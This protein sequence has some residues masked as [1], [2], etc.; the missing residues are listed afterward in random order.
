MSTLPPPKALREGERAPERRGR[1][2]RQVL[3]VHFHLEQFQDPDLLFEQ[4]L[5]L[6]EDI[7]PVHQPYPQDHSVDLDITGAL[8]LFDRSS[9]ELA[10]LLQLRAIALFGVRATV[11]GGP[12]LLISAM[13]AAAT[14]FGHIT[15]I[16]DDDASVAAFLRPR[17][18]AA[19]PGIG[20]ATAKTL[21][22][23][24]ISTIGQLADTPAGPLIRLLGAH[25][26]R[27]LHARA[28]GLDDRPVRRTALVRSTS[29]SHTFEADELD[30]VAHRRELLA[31]ADELG[32]RLRA[33]GEVCRG[34]TLTV[35][36][37]DRTHTTRSRTLA[38]PTHHTPALSTHSYDLYMRLGLE[39]ARV[40]QL[41][42]RADQLGPA[43][44]AH[45]QLL[46]DDGDDKA[47]R[48]EAASDAARARFGPHVIQPAAT[49]VRRSSPPA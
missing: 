9:H 4:L 3:R 16:A 10:Q 36:Y 46:F 1:P 6:V 41:S 48:L 27:E 35:R 42:L 33:T 44:G 26:A 28:H 40:R 45:H 25:A 2:R 15:V 38:E 49:A 32:A 43:D 19:L 31:L 12:S 5:L 7:T 39:R 24:G 20:P 13:A 21:N 30:P 47:R 37:A 17:P 29:T 22:R 14:P 23:Y 18:L 34:L 8:R 11:G